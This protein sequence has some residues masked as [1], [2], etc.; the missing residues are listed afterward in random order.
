VRKN[1][2]NERGPRLASLVAICRIVVGDVGPA[3]L[4][5]WA[6]GTASAGTTIIP[7]ANTTVMTEVAWA[8]LSTD[9]ERLVKWW[10]N[11]G[12][13]FFRA[14]SDQGCRR[15]GTGLGTRGLRFAAGR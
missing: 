8:N 4:A 9:V 5:P 6:A 11:P 1:V 2:I 13:R 3:V 7:I 15:G 14:A 12:H 10:K